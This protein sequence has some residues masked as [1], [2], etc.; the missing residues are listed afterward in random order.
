M[1]KV[2]TKC[3][4]KKSLDSFYKKSRNKD[5][6]TPQCIACLREYSK[7]YLQRTMQDRLAYQKEY[8][9]QNKEKVSENARRYHIE[10]LGKSRQNGKKYRLRHPDK[11]RLKGQRY[12]KKNMDYF[13]NKARERRMRLME[14]SDGSVTLQFESELLCLQEGKCAYCR[15]LLTKKHLDHILAISNGGLHTWSNVHWTCPPCNISKFNNLESEWLQKVKIDPS[16]VWRH[17]KCSSSE[18]M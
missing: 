17:P 16:T 3:L 18:T 10:N 9:K 13:L 1:K 14:V 6:R 12:R 8:R 15:R 11:L 2:C 4:K 5:G 7:E